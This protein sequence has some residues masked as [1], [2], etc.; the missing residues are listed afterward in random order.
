M[1]PI[2]WLQSDGVVS[3]V[4]VIAEFVVVKVVMLKVEAWINFT[5]P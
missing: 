2:R 3:M 5:L 4:M 1:F